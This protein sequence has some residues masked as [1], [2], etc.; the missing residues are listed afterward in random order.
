MWECVK[1]QT[2]EN[3]IRLLQYK[4][5]HFK[6]N[7]EFKPCVYLAVQ[8][9]NKET[10]LRCRSPFVP[11]LALFSQPDPTEVSRLSHHALCHPPSYQDG[12]REWLSWPGRWLVEDASLRRSPGGF[13]VSRPPSPYPCLLKQ[14]SHSPGE[15]AKG[16][17]TGDNRS[18]EPLFWYH[19]HLWKCQSGYWSGDIAEKSA[20]H[21]L[22]NKWRR[23]ECLE[24]SRKM[25]NNAVELNERKRRSRLLSK[26]R[27]LDARS[28]SEISER[29][30]TAR[31]RCHNTDI[32]EILIW[33]K[34]NPPNLRGKWYFSFIP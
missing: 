30:R 18:N 17:L 29:R 26:Q 10:D 19:R 16:A 6:F 20:D 24:T 27:T 12:R 25:E 34:P 11:F 3:N 14:R 1:T 31:G 15:R 9:T 32:L 21:L 22:M 5:N 33:T 2:R 7:M 13:C 28:H 23:Y 8:T 4:K